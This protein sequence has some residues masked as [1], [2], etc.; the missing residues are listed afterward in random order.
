[1]FGGLR[2]SSLVKSLGPAG[3]APIEWPARAELRLH[4]S[5][6][7]QRAASL[8]RRGRPSLLLLRSE[9]RALPPI[10]GATQ[11]APL[12]LSSAV[13]RSASSPSPGRPA[14]EPPAPVSFWAP[15]AMLH[16]SPPEGSQRPGI[17]SAVYSLYQST[18]MRS[19]PRDGQGMGLVFADN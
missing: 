12:L 16:S 6:R 18:P 1:M 5:G 19:T 3:L 10:K 4:S 9:R 2:S 15:A 7:A 17:P 13:S 11:L 8:A 14:L